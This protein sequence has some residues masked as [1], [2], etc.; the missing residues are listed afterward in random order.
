MYTSIIV[1]W[2]RVFL[3]KTRRFFF[4][5]YTTD[6]NFNPWTND[7]TR[8]H[9]FWTTKNYNFFRYVWFKLI[10]KKTKIQL[11]LLDSTINY[12]FQTKRLK[13]IDKA[14]ETDISALLECLN[15]FEIKIEIKHKVAA[16]NEFLKHM[17][18]YKNFN[19]HELVFNICKTVL[20]N[21]I[22]FEGA[23]IS[24]SIELSDKKDLLFLKLAL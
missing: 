6:I 19:N 12:D 14:N 10:K 3:F 18:Q 2:H 8:L 15:D 13:I 4:G 17:V 7:L 20:T 23:S 9:L 24:I 11:N 22:T 5:N 1:R 21:D 16:I